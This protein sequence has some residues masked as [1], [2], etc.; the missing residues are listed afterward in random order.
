MP[1]LLLVVRYVL[2][3]ILLTNYSSIKGRRLF[4]NQLMLC[5]G[6]VTCNSKW[7]PS[8]S[9]AA[10]LFVENC[11]LSVGVVPFLCS[12]VWP[13]TTLSFPEIEG[14]WLNWMLSLY[15]YFICSLPLCCF[16]RHY[17]LERFGLSK[18]LV[19]FFKESLENGQGK[20]GNTQGGCFRSRLTQLAHALSLLHMCLFLP[21][22]FLPWVGADWDLLWDYEGVPPHWG[23]VTMWI[24]CLWVNGEYLF[25]ERS[26]PSNTRVFR[27][28][29]SVISRNYQGQIWGKC[30]ENIWSCHCWAWYHDTQWHLLCVHSRT[31]G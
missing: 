4:C 23:Q 27:C 5:F 17:D 14:F 6:S 12:S 8:D 2:I 10:S 11:V 3:L 15:L 22:H 30:F 26:G 7:L 29:V 20:S 16:A 1:F 24:S 13:Q 28:G 25:T 9:L 19:S 18:E 31:H 21:Y